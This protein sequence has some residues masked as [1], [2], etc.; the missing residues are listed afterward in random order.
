MKKI[1][2]AG[3]KALKRY[4]RPPAPICIQEFQVRSTGFSVGVDQQVRVGLKSALCTYGQLDST[5]FRRWA[6]TLGEE[7]RPHRKLWEHCFIGA[8][9]EMHGCL[10]AGKKGV[11]FAVG[12]EALPSVFA[13]RQASILATD[14]PE[15]DSRSRIW[16]PSGQWARGLG[17]LNSRGLCSQESFDRLVEFR[18]VDMTQIPAD[19]TGFDFSWSSCA[20]EHLGSIEA[21]LKFLER[22][23]DCL[24]DG[25]IAVH[26]TEFNLTSNDETLDVG[27]TVIF[28]LRDIESIL[29]RLTGQGHAVEPVSLDLG[30]HELDKYVD[31]RPYSKVNHLRLE[32]QGFACTSIALIIKK[33]G[34]R[35][36]VI[37]AD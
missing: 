24:V 2:K 5:L 8:A 22:Q 7:W 6:E 27:R 30:A 1:L 19:L 32:Y 23:M 17:A 10:S 14:L 13:A 37:R 20:L 15:A 36:G 11:G 28:R 35:R 18:P 25:G 26:T 29:D 3:F 33:N 16:A 12:T 21:G 9:L 31:Q 4:L 34:L